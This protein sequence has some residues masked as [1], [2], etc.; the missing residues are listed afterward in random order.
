MTPGSTG[1]SDIRF[2]ACDAEL[3]P[4]TA[5]HGTLRIVVTLTASDHRRRPGDWLPAPLLR[6][7]VETHTYQQ[8]IPYTDRLNY[9]SAIITNVGYCMTVEKLLA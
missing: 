6:E 7:D 5:T 8:V 3:G 1:A 2:R 9:C 4:S